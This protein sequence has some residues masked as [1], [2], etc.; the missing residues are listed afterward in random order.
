MTEYVPGDH[1][2]RLHTIHGQAVHAQELWQE[3]IAVTLHYELEW[4]RG[5]AEGQRSTW[6]NWVSLRLRCSRTFTGSVVALETDQW[7]RALTVLLE[8]FRRTE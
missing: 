4:R 6:S 1:H 2:V 3:G 7:L 5:R 8:D